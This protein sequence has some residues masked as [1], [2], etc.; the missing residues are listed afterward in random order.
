Q[1]KR[2]RLNHSTS[3]HSSSSHSSSSSST[4]LSAAASALTA[5]RSMVSTVMECIESVH[6]SVADQP[7]RA[8]EINELLP[9]GRAFWSKF[10]PVNLSSYA[11]TDLLHTSAASTASAASSISSSSASA[12]LEVPIHLIDPTKAEAA[13]KAAVHLQH[14]L[15]A[16]IEEVAFDRLLSSAKS[17]I[18]AVRLVN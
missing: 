18:D 5:Y 10:M 6:E 1:S 16:V 17:T 13:A 4:A 14:K 7:K 9:K 15:T 12:S 2:R 3:P 8:A 11:A